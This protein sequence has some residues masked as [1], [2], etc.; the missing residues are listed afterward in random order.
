M[1]VASPPVRPSPRQAESAPEPCSVQRFYPPPIEEW[2]ETGLPGTLLEALV[3]KCLFTS[4]EQTG[5]NVS[6]ALALPPKPVLDVLQSLKN[7]QLAYYKDSATMGDFQYALSEAGRDRARKLLD[8]SMYVGAAP[9]PFEY[10]VESVSAQSITTEKPGVKE[11]QAAFS[12]VVI[13][14]AMQRRLGPA[15]NSGRGLFLYGAP[16]NGKTTMAERITRCFGSHIWIPHAIYVDGEIIKFYDPQSHIAVGSNGPSVLK[17]E[18]YDPRWIKIERPT[19]IVG[20]ELTM[21]S[22]ELQFNPFTKITEPSVQLKSNCG[23]LVIDDFGRQRMAPVDLLN[24][25]IVPLEKR[26]DYLSLSTGTKIQVPFDQLIIF[27]TNLEPRELVDDAF[28]R[29]IPYKINVLDPPVDQY[30]DLMKF[31]ADL[32][33]IEYVHDVVEDLIERHY[34]QCNRPLR[35]CHPRDLLLQIINIAAYNE[36]EVKMTKEAFDAAVDNYFAV[37]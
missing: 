18:N 37:M 26:F 19:I 12:D 3:I 13:S 2:R 20:G 14:D 22:L 21:E 28:L 10:Y 29:R 36:C 30:R 23:T 11:V 15:I 17:G 4:G 27:S 32:F 25:W 7:A 24:R 33:N 9:V 6:K 1:Q 31:T 34:L 16:G 8:E 35:C 5:R